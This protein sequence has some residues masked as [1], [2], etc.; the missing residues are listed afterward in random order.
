MEL[1][2]FWPRE[3]FKKMSFFDFQ[4]LQLKNVIGFYFIILNIYP[5]LVESFKKRQ[6]SFDANSFMNNVHTVF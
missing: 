5:W 6:V 3:I 1:R 2:K 4:E